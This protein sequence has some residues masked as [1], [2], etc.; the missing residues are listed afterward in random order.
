MINKPIY[1]LIFIIPIIF[2]CIKEE[3]PIQPHQQGG[4]SVNQVDMGPDYEQQIFYNLNDTSVISTNLRTDWDLGFEC[5]INGWHIILNNSLGGK[6]ANTND[7]SFSAI[8][9]LIGSEDWKVD[10]PNGN[11]DS[12][13]IEDYRTNNEVY[14]LDRGYDIQGNSIGYKK[15][16]LLYFNN[17]QNYEIRIANLDG[18]ED[19]TLILNKDTTLNFMALSLNTSALVTIE[20]NKETWDLLFTKYLE[21]FTGFGPYGVTGVIIN[22]NNTEVAIDTI[23]DFNEISYELIQQYNFNSG[24]N[25]IG[26]DWKEYDFNSSS[27]ILDVTKNYIIRNQFGIYFKLRFI[28][29]YDDIGEKGAPKFELQ[30]L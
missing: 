4:V 2:G 28:D 24:L 18:S 20:P 26:Y 12:T 3:L 19:T 1:L 23:N 11:L 16:K 22:R 29:F 27:Y 10:S 13:A 15:L 6:I 5:S 21:V 14:I 17:Q 8:T 25:S 9:G 30:K 7:T